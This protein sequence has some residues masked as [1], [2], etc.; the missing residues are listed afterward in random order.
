MRVFGEEAEEDLFAKRIFDF[1][2]LVTCH[3]ESNGAHELSF[4][5]S[6]WECVW[7]GLCPSSGRPTA[8]IFASADLTVVSDSFRQSPKDM[9]SKAEPWNQ[10]PHLMPLCMAR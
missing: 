9:G 8:H 3:S 1:V 10:L 4:P 7:L 2:Q 5:G 6:A